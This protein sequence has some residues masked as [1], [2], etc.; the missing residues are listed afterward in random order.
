M[1]L[2]KKICIFADEKKNSFNI[3]F[4]QSFCSIKYLYER[5]RAQIWHR[6]PNDM[7]IKTLTE[8]AKAKDGNA[9][10]TLYRM[11]FPKMLGL[12]IKIA[13]VDED[14][15]KDL[16]HDAFV[17]A[18]SSLHNLNNPERFGEWLTT[19][20]RNVA[21]KYLERKEKIHFVPITE[22]DE[23][24]VDGNV[25]TESLLQQQEL[26]N[27]VDK[28]PEGYGKVFRLYAIDGFSHQEIAEI[29]GIEPHSSS[30]QLSRAKA[31]LRKMVGQKRWAILLLMILTIPFYIFFLREKS[32]SQKQETA[33]KN[34]E[35]YD[36]S[37]KKNEGNV[38]EEI[39]IENIVH[40]KI[41]AENMTVAMPDTMLTCDTVSM[42]IHIPEEQ[43]AEN[44]RDS[45][46]FTDSIQPM[47]QI[48]D[49]PDFNLAAEKTKKKPKKW[50]MLAAGSLGPA[51]AQ[52]IYRLMTA[53]NVGD[54]DA[55]SVPSKV[56][57]WED[58]SQILNSSKND[59][60][61]KDSL[62][63]IEIANNNQGDIIEQEYYD[64]PV[65]FGLSLSKQ[66]SER[67]NVETGLQYSILKSKSIIGSNEYHIRKDQNIHYLGIPLRM[68]YRFADYKRLSVYGA[69]GVSLNIPIYN[70]VYRKYIAANIPQD[71]TATR[72]SI[73]PPLQW[74]ANLS[75]G[76]QYR[77]LPKLTLYVEPTLY[78]YIPNGSSTHTVWT[79]HPF[80]FSAPLGI[81]FTW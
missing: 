62:A 43:I 26:M 41:A 17:L 16:V 63:L 14:T 61:P 33:E 47:L 32:L 7:D 24:A 73:T 56:S 45:I 59:H 30:S 60:M 11:Y 5:G 9:L 69:A 44:K 12:C 25:S 53:D 79:E 55:P 22:D 72:I 39:K 80:T 6:L 65:T 54:T 52:N 40:E 31:M 68:S 36:K 49:L 1:R 8:R 38:E 3:H 76:L 10:D 37:E 15:A 64:R 51:L 21:L 75:L 28:L 70:K 35:K 67:W 4:M 2:S 48:P 42:E 18:F 81:R 71:S 13:K 74:S 29:L 23:N 77:V 27:L 34:K 19:I 58:Y 20:V 57:N 50:Q 78:W 66:L 46:E